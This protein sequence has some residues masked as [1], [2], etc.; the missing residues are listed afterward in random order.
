MNYLRWGLVVVAVIAT[1]WLMTSIAAVPGPGRG[2]TP[3]AAQG[4][5]PD[6]RGTIE[7]EIRDAT[8][9]YPNLVVPLDA[10]VWFGY[11]GANL[12]LSWT[13]GDTSVTLYTPPP[14]C[15]TQPQKQCG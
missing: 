7:W 6:V 13:E 3:T 14:E 5:T 10:G 1:A 2:A 15:Q 8:A 4:T 11:A 9:P 12:Y